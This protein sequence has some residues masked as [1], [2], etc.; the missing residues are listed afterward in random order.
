[1][2][3]GWRK[4]LAVSAVFYL[5]VVT[6]LFFALAQR[7]STFLQHGQT[8]EG[9]VV[10]IGHASNSGSGPFRGTVPTSAHRIATISYTLDGVTDTVTSNP[11]SM[12]RTY[13]I[14]Q[15]VTLVVHRSS[16][17]S[18]QVVIV[19]DRAQAGIRAVPYLFLAAALILAWYF[20]AHRY[21]GA[22]RGRRRIDGR[23]DSAKQLPA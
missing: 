18:E 14:G 8:I 23:R 19:K 17:P 2:K 20:G 1:M 5:L 6:C 21:P 11:Y 22:L 13:T 12:S 15:P 10:A 16:D 9:K 7:T 3:K 4:I